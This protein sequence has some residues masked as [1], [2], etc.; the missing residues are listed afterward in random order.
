MLSISILTG[1]KV[2]YAQVEGDS[3]KYLVSEETV[4]SGFGAPFVDFSSVN[5]EFAVCLGGGAAMLINHTVY[6]GGF[7]EGIMTNHYRPD[8]HNVVDSDKPKISLEQGGIWLGYIY[9]HQKAVHG[10]ISMKL[11]WGEIDLKDEGNGNPASDYDYRD[12]IFAVTPQAELELNLT[13]WFKINIGV[14]YRFV[15]GIDATYNDEQGKDV[16]FYNPGDFNSPVG[17]VT[18]VF[19]GSDKKK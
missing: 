7:F 17:T 13:K 12:R 19:G 9:K 5:N 14:G 1:N 3:T 2:I 6:I 18:L 15:N 16:D 10:G 8:L 4:L 11:G